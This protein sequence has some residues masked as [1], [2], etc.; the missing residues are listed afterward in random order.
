MGVSNLTAVNRHR[1]QGL[2]FDLAS[3]RQSRYPL[4]RDFTIGTNGL[5]NVVLVQP[6]GTP[7]S[8]RRLRYRLQPRQRA[9]GRR[10]KRILGVRIRLGP[11]LLRT[12]VD[13]LIGRVTSRVRGTSR[14]SVFAAC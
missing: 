4:G 6:N 13:R 12:S 7:D 10:I 5:N 11:I 1:I 14:R 3:E 2:R 8:V 9:L